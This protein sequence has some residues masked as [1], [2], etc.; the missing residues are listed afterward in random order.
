MTK[1]ET[2]I[3]S[4][5]GTQTSAPPKRG[6]VGLLGWRLSLL[7]W[8]RVALSREF[9]KVLAGSAFGRRSLDVRYFGFITATRNQAKACEYADSEETTPISP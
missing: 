5:M 9:L 2:L 1:R 7:G 3:G 8:W 4:A 6:L